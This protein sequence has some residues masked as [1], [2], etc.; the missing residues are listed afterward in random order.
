MGEYSVIS[1]VF[2]GDPINFRKDIYDCWLEGLSVDAAA[3]K[4]K[5]S[6]EPVTIDGL[7]IDELIHEDILDSV[8]LMTFCDFVVSY[9]WVL[10]GAAVQQ[11]LEYCRLQQ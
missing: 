5:E 9:F 11:L 8:S 7:N 4:I 2:I 6:T 1:E 3:Q 10:Q